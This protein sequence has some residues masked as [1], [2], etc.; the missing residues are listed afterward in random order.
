MTA[1]RRYSI[2]ADWVVVGT[3]LF[4]IVALAGVFR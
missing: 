4:G 1:H 2:A 3:L